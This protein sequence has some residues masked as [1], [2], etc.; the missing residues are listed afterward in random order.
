MDMCIALLY[1]DLKRSDL[2]T[3]VAV[4][5]TIVICDGSMKRQFTKQRTFS[6][7]LKIRPLRPLVVTW[8]KVSTLRYPQDSWRTENVS[9]FLNL[10]RKLSTLCLIRPSWRL[11]ITVCFNSK[12]RSVINRSCSTLVFSNSFKVTYAAR[13][14]CDL[15]TVW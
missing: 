9:T 14:S 13:P 7:R 3:Q 10:C 6:E 1:G 8:T 5:F 12:N 11:S 2:Y 4:S 15:H